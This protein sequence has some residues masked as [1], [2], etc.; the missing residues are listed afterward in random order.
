MEEQA[1]ILRKNDGKGAATSGEK[2]QTA[3][4]RSEVRDVTS[5]E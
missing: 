1:R 4:F 5:R 3:A 2:P